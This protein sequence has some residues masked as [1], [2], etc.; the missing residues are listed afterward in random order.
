MNPFT[1]S[2]LLRTPLVRRMDAMKLLWFCLLKTNSKPYLL[3]CIGGDVSH[4]QEVGA[5]T[6]RARG[7]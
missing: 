4:V 7:R 1:E 2:E 6:G 3:V 5:G